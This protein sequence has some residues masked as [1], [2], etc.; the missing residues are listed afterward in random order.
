MK[1]ELIQGRERRTVEVKESAKVREVLKKGGVNLETVLVRRGREI[2]TEEEE[3]REGDVL[4]LI[5][6]ISGG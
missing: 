2:V 5:R 1:V 4:E 3:V 6:V